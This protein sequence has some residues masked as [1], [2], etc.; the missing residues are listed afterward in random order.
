MGV[1]LTFCFRGFADAQRILGLVFPEEF[2]DKW[3]GLCT[4]RT[5]QAQEA[6][7]ET[8]VFSLHCCRTGVL[9]APFINHVMGLTTT[10]ALE[11]SLDYYTV[12]ASTA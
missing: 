1:G 5:I 6:E 4:A 7:K 3:K 2:C 12:L 11:L 10:T 8:G 9:Q